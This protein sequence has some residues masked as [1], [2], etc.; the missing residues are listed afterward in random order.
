MTDLKNRRTEEPD[1][2]PSRLG[3]KMI[4][5]RAAANPRSRLPVSCNRHPIS[6]GFFP[7]LAGMNR[8]DQGINTILKRTFTPINAINPSYDSIHPPL[9]LMIP[10]PCGRVPIWGGLCPVR[11]GI[12]T[13]KHSPHLLLGAIPLMGSAMPPIG[14]AMALLIQM[15]HPYPL[16]LTP[17]MSGVNPA[18][19]GLLPDSQ[20]IPT[21]LAMTPPYPAEIHPML[22]GISVFACHPNLLTSGSTAPPSKPPARD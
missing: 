18:G 14:P 6:H 12:H 11:L 15:I 4:D 21:T 9:H 3:Q 16:G 2:D 8:L 17:I 5:C 19:H 13:P 1:R 10:L 7:N 20:A 22:T